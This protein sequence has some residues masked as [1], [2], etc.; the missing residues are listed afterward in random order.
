MSDHSRPLPDRP[1]LRYLKTEAK[2]RLGAGEFPT[3]HDAHLA[4]A[5]EHGQP[6]WTVLKRLVESQSSP[7]RH[8]GEQLRW[9]ASR[10]A[11]AADPDWVS[12]PDSELREHFHEKLLGA[13]PD[14]RLLPMLA[15]LAPRLQPAALALVEDSPTHA[16]VQL[17][18]GQLQAVVEPVAPHRLT[19]LRAYGTGRVSDPRLSAPP[20]ATTGEVPAAAVHVAARAFAELGLVGLALAGG[21]S[22]DAVWALAHGWAGLDPARPLTNGHRFPAA[23][24]TRLITATA[25]LRL[26]AEGRIALDTPADRQLGTHRPSDPEATVRELLSSAPGE[27]LGDGASADAGYA[28]LGRIVAD[29]VQVPFAEA[30]ARL[31]LAPLGM[32]AS[33][34]P[35]RRPGSG[36]DTVD[37]YTTA[38]DGT[39]E[40]LRGQADTV[41]AAEGL[42]T[43]ATDLVRFGHGWR[44]LL[45]VALA[46]EALTPQAERPGGSRMGLGW[47]LDPTGGIVGHPGTAPGA[48]A[49]L[50]VRGPQVHVALTNRS[51]PVEPVNGRILRALE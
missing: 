19:G 47:Q 51:V 37:G 7:G 49:S 1:N 43:T 41:S 36:P 33:Y 30:V 26:V 21:G 48:S 5:R 46:A 29:V 9:I 40:P 10:F 42:W 17:D 22:P 38:P 24:V 34:F 8:A 45:P 20:T 35:T 3:L 13:F 4:V 50:V 6:S 28:A 15:S 14:G 39:V 23:S 11:G 44:T 32:S 27:L 18:G 31:V 16:L 2:R 12:P 25:V